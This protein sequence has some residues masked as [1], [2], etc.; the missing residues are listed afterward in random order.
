MRLAELKSFWPLTFGD[1][2]LPQLAC[3]HG[4]PHGQQVTEWPPEL[5][6]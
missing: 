6:P 3:H 4:K 1:R 2:R 5:T